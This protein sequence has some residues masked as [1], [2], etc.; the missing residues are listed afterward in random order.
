[1]Q[2]I[3]SPIL[4]SAA[5]PRRWAAIATAITAVHKP[6][7]P[8]QIAAS[9]ATGETSKGPKTTE[10]RTKCAAPPAANS[11]TCNSLKPSSSP[12]NP[13]NI[14]SAHPLTEPN[15]TLSGKRN[16]FLASGNHL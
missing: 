6:A 16:R 5:P 13:A 12:E 3:Q 11:N 2:D 15:T 10:G 1:M 14:H 7:N 9:L 8:K 4:D